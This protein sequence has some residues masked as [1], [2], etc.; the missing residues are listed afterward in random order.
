M[1]NKNGSHKG[2][3]EQ[4]RCDAFAFGFIYDDD[5]GEELKVETET[6]SETDDVC[7]TIDLA[8]SSVTNSGLGSYGSGR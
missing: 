7:I 6:N 1:R 3:G 2:V 4:D 8:G 5:I